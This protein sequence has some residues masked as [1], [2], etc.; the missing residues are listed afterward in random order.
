MVFNAAP[1]ELFVIRNVA[2]LVP[3]YGPDDQPHGISAAIEFAVRSLKVGAIVIL[4]LS[5]AGG[6]VRQQAKSRTGKRS[7]TGAGKEDGGG[8]AAG[9]VGDSSGRSGSPRRSTD[10]TKL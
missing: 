2:N 6:R 7:S 9:V 5:A 8:D 3:P 1:G 4:M 10:A